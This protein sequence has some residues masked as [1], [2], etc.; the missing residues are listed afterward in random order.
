MFDPWD[1]V[2]L[3]PTLRVRWSRTMPDSMLGAT[4]GHRRI[5]LNRR[6]LHSQAEERCTL[7]HEL[8]HWEWSH[9]GRQPAAVEHRVR[10]ATAALLIRRSD[11]MREVR[12]TQDVYEL[13]ELLTVTPVVLRDRL[14]MD[15]VREALQKRSLI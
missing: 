6:Q 15:D 8:V 13:A 7:T 10:E 9:V 5:W 11:L 14:V 2:R 12:W 4:D 1:L 3:D